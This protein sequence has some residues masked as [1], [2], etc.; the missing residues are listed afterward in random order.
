MHTGIFI[1]WVLSAAW[2]S[3]NK[4]FIQHP[5]F[6]PT[7]LNCPKIL[8]ANSLFLKIVGDKAA[9]APVLICTPQ[10]KVHLQ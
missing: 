7:V 8:G 9:I 3:V 4:I 5:Q 1:L 6:L 2:L 10:A